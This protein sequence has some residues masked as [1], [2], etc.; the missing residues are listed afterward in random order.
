[1]QKKETIF[2]DGFIAKRK[3][4][5]KDFLVVK[6]SLKAD[7]ATAFISKH[8]KN[9]W[10]NLEVKRSKS[11]SLYVELDTFVPQKQEGKKFEPTDELEF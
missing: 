7:E 6:L 4:D 9:G 2:A 8:E 1:M 5:A 11:G 10:I 3:D